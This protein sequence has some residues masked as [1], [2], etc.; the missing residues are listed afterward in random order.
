MDPP[1]R[2]H[3]PPARAVHPD[4]G[5]GDET[6]SIHLTDLRKKHIPIL[7]PAGHQAGMDSIRAAR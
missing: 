3:D 1:C 5:A 6:V 4:A 2:Q 7:A